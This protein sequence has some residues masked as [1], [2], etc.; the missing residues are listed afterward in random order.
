VR[1]Y[2]IGVIGD[3]RYL[4]MELLIGEDLFSRM[5]KPLTLD[6]GLDYLIQ[7]CAG[8]QAAHEKGVIHRDVK[9]ENFFITQER[10]LKVLDFGVA[11]QGASRL[12][13]MGTIGGTPQYISPE[14]INNFGAVGPSADI[15]SLGVV[16]YHM[17]TGRL[18]FDHE[19]LGPLLMMHLM[20]APAP[21][22][23]LNPG[24]PIE[25]ER[26]ILATLEKDPAKRPA[27]CT[28]LAQHLM[29]VRKAIA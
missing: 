13:V 1:L 20:Q 17:C 6:E 14:Q 9:S 23:Q 28:E 25:L 12:T 7:A 4:T 15:Y 10:V 19:E 22:R 11:K 3:Y 16:A 8:L 26:L 21:P 29:A 5:Q 2:D 27:S 18:P 24:L